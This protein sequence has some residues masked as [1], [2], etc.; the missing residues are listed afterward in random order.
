[1]DQK[2]RKLDDDGNGD[3]DNDNALLEQFRKEAIWR[4]MREYKRQYE[5]SLNRLQDLESKSNSLQS[6]L[7]SVEVCWN[8]LIDVLQLVIVPSSSIQSNDALKDFLEYSNSEDLA[9][10]NSAL[11][12]RSGATKELIG[13]VL[14]TATRNQ[15]PDAV[16]LQKQAHM[17][18]QQSNS[19]KQELR[20]TRLQLDDCKS[21][22]ESTRDKLL[23][24][25]KQ[26]DRVKS[27]L[28]SK[29]HQE[30]K[31]ISSDSPIPQPK[32][33]SVDQ[34]KSEPS[35]AP[36]PVRETPQPPPP[37]GPT[38]EELEDA[39][40]LAMQRMT[41][42]VELRAEKIKLSQ[43][44]DSLRVTLRR[45]NDEAILESGL[46]RDLQQQ[47][48]HFQSDAD[49]AK[50]KYNKLQ[51]EFEGIFTSRREFED[52]LKAD[53][54]SQLDAALQKLQVKEADINRLRGQREELNSELNVR[55]TKDSTKLQH[56]EQTQQLS[57]SRLERIRCLNSEIQRLKGRIAA[58]YGNENVY[59]AIM[60]DSVTEEDLNITIRLDTQL[61]TANEEI[62][63]LKSQISNLQS[64]GDLHVR[65]EQVETK[66]QSYEKAF[67]DPA[68]PE[69]QNLV[70]QI[71]KKDERI[72]TLELQNVESETTSNAI[73]G[74]IE[75]LSKA[76]EVL[77]EQNRSKIFD[78]Q[79]L[80]EKVSRLMTEKAKSDNKYFAA[81]R[82]KDAVDI[83]RKTALR[84]HEKQSKTIERL[85]D[86]E[87]QL[88]QQISIHEK[89]LMVY[90]SKTK[91]LE[92]KVFTTERE[93]SSARLL[94][95]ESK[96]RLMEVST[97]LN[98]R[99]VMYE[100]ERAAKKRL[101]ED[102]TKLRSDLQRIPHNQPV[103]SGA[104][105]GIHN[106]KEE[107]LQRER[108]QLFVSLSNRLLVG[109]F[110][111]TTVLT[112]LFN[113]LP[114]LDSVA[115]ALGLNFKRPSDDSVDLTSSCL[116][117]ELE[118]DE[119]ARLL[120]SRCVL[121]KYIIRLLADGSTY[122][123]LHDNNKKAEYLWDQYK[124]STFSVN[125][126]AAYISLPREK[127]TAIIE[128]FSYMQLRGKVRCKNPEVQFE[129]YEE[130]KAIDNDP[131]IDHFN[132]QRVLHRVYFGTFLADGQRG[133]ISK[134]DVK[135]R[136]YFGNTSMESEVT[137]LMANQALARKGTLV[138][139]PFAGT[140][141]M[142][143]LCA[144]FGSYVMGSDLDGRQMRG[145]AN[146]QNKGHPDSRSGGIIAAA[147]DY[148]VLDKF[149]DLFTAD[150][151]RIGWRLGGTLNA[152]V[153]DPPYGVRAGAKRIGLKEGAKS[154]ESYSNQLI[155][156]VQDYDLSHLAAD[157]VVMSAYLLKKGG[158][159]V[160]FLPTV[161]EEY[162]E[163]DVPTCQG[164]RIIANS[165]QD[166]GKWS[167]RLITMEKVEDVE[168]TESLQT[169][170]S[171]LD[172]NKGSE[173]VSHAK[174]REKFFK[175][176]K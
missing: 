166:F 157:L 64:G 141:S 72:K 152:I 165:V 9:L 39:R 27:S 144:F 61:K 161:N 77:D 107:N 42:S 139:D 103:S 35:Q 21:Q 175:A 29:I 2:K 170:L 122:E 148:G 173:N 56:I 15:S 115:K 135:K 174:F 84:T 138:W 1:M 168:T 75:R 119:Q 172:I 94:A 50:I 5:H 155:P 65:L 95:D 55:R 57:E 98:E 46:Y 149:L 60:G 38:K 109:I 153:T 7:S 108:D 146:K 23:N 126:E 89:E 79:H 18:Q 70:N 145:Q 120:A 151:T 58:G 53:A 125:V 176:F 85:V 159:L 97:K 116:V 117:V 111:K 14:T 12:V 3:L 36:S 59:R 102:N 13:S 26:V 130:H 69:V 83:E 11:S 160:Y 133:L 81:M 101:E 140:G 91:A 129:V 134:F 90:S 150:V 25:E 167:R 164:M 142:L 128:Q 137:V 121:I 22:W 114:E 66:L 71:N 124:D 30:T 158:R 34:I 16:H 78:L 162:K 118:T 28:I 110:N 169:I 4:Q 163:T 106:A 127:R 82:A 43:E 87:K 37:P 131:A 96:R 62:E 10:L 154:K 99:H 8:E 113:L 143:Y 41:E 147:K 52:R 24:A 136:K 19:Y 92:D 105:N 76:W 112:S 49:T 86:T 51:K 123:E 93:L 104:M 132:K 17:Y 171:N 44:V 100:D 47:I 73:Y 31:P 48:G 20:L 80:E 45:P 74:E 54:N 156:P 67:S 68:D 32:T 6:S 63:A 40:K 88:Q 33:D